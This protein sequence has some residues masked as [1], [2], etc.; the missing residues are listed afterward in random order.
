MPIITLSRIEKES[1]GRNGW[2]HPAK[3]AVLYGPH[4]TIAVE[5]WS[6]NENGEPPI[7]LYLTMQDARLLGKSLIRMTEIG[8][9]G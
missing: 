8:T 4:D 9:E 3:V 6:K 2:F 5:V 7:D 1:K